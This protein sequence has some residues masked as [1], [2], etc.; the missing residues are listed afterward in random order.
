MRISLVARPASVRDSR[1]RKLRAYAVASRFCRI[2]LVALATKRKQR[3]HRLIVQLFL[4][5]HSR[6]LPISLR[7]VCL[8]SLSL[9]F[10]LKKK[11][12]KNVSQFSYFI[13]TYVYNRCEIFGEK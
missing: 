10:S 11:K 12:K 2:T 13:T 4:E 8:L 6:G 9:S 3:E 1:Y 5:T 7:V